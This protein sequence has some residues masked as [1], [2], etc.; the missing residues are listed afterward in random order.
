MTAPRKQMLLFTAI[1]SFGA[2]M[3]LASSLLVCCLQTLYVKYV[4]RITH[5]FTCYG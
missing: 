1:L 2:D 4:Q 5:F 3:L